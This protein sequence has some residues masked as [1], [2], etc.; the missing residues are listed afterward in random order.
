MA[1]AP[2][3]PAKSEL[4]RS[5]YFPAGGTKPTPSG[6][7]SRDDRPADGFDPESSATPNYLG[8]GGGGVGAGGVS[9]LAFPPS[10]DGAAAAGVDGLE[11]QPADT[12]RPIATTR[13]PKH[14]NMVRSPW[15]G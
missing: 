10:L 9:L 11:S 15:S 1:A 6:G 14:L 13:P 2:T 12:A 7:P 5:A 3:V 8:G 4:S